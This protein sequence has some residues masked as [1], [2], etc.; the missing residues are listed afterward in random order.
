MNFDYAISDLLVAYGEIWR[1]NDSIS[2]EIASAK[3][4]ITKQNLEYS[5]KQMIREEIAEAKNE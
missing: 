4:Q 5:I 2:L 1:S 3:F